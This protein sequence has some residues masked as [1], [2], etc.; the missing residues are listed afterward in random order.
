MPPT[1]TPRPERDVPE[2]RSLGPQ[3]DKK[4]H[5]RHADVLLRVLADRSVSAPKNIALAGHYGSGKS[6][7]IL[8][9]QE[10]LDARDIKWVNLSLSSLGTDN[11]KRGRVQEDGTLAPLTNLIQKE[12]VKQLLYRKAPKDMPGSRYFRIDSFRTGRAVQ[13]AIAAGAGVFA[14]AVLLGLVG[15]VEK[16]APRW[17]ANGP[18]WAPWAAVG[19]LG[20]FA[21]LLCFLALR[22]LQN[23]IKVDSISAGGA[24]VSLSAKENSYFDEYLDEIV[25]F[26]QQTK[27]Q[28]AI[29]EDLDRFKDP[30]IFETLRELNTVLNNSEQVKSRPVKFVYAVRDSIFE[31]L[32]VA[33]TGTTE[34]ASSEAEP[35][36][37]EPGTRAPVVA[38]GDLALRASAQES[39]PSANRTKFFDLVVPMVPF[40]THRSARDLL[41]EE[42]KTSPQR[43]SAAVINLIGG[44]R[45]LTDMRLI[46]NIRNEFEIYRASVLS[47]HGLQGLTA[48]R[49]FAM[50]V[51]KN[52][53]LEDFEAIRH[54]TSRI[55]LAHRAFRQFVEHQSRAQTSRSKAA[56][57]RA[58]SVIPWDQRARAVGKRLQQTL[59]LLQRANRN[60]GGA[61]P[62]I[63]TSFGTYTLADLESA[64]FWKK[65]H[66]SRESIEVG[67]P[68]YYPVTLAFD[69]FLMLGGDAGMAIKKLVEVDVAE[70]HRQS[71][72]ALDTR[73]FVTTATMAELIAR[74]DLTMP[75]EGSAEEL[76]LDEIVSGIVSPLAH[77]LLAQGLL[78]ENFTLYCSDYQGVAISVSAM[79]FILHCVQADQADPL[80]H[81]DAPA[82]I[83]AVENEVG[84]RFLSGESVFNVEVFDHYLTKNALRLENALGRLVVRASSGDT[85]FVDLYL[86]DEKVGTKHE[87]L[88]A[89][90]PLWPGV[91]AHLVEA[92]TQEQQ[93]EFVDTAL[94]AAVTD[95]AY[96]ASETLVQ[97]LS[98]RYAEM[99][100]FTEPLTSEQASTLV[101]LMDDLNMQVPD[102]SLLGEQQRRAVVAAGL[103]P[104]TRANLIAALNSAGGRDA[105]ASEANDVSLALDAAKATDNDIYTH[106][107][108]NLH[109]YLAALGTGEVTVEDADEFLGVLSDVLGA[110][111]GLLQ[112]VAERA[113]ESCV[114]RDLTTL[115]Q[116]GWLPVVAA[117]RFLASAS[118]VSHYVQHH[119]VTSELA[120]SLTGH[121][122]I[123]AADVD[124]EE[125]TTLAYALVEA[126][127]LSSTERVRLL[128]QL[129]FSSYLEP[130][131]LGPGGLS[132]LPELLAAGEV[133]DDANTYAVVA[134]R[135]YPFREKYFASAPELAS[136]VTELALSSDDLNQVMKSRDVP[137]NVKK[138][139]AAAPDFI[140]AHISQ[141]VA[142]TICDWALKGNDVSPALVL[143]LSQAGAPAE[144]V[145]PILEAHLNTM[146][147]GTLDAVLVALG[148][149]YEP[150]TRRG[151]HRP[152]LKSRAGTK[153][154]LDE[155]KRRDRVSSYADAM[156]G[157]IRVN[158][159]A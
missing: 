155:L 147:L 37:S 150:L 88:A 138:A 131:R 151:R 139:I 70:L 108:D 75:V 113:S 144:K 153:E 114:V 135:P 59:P 34:D 44:H 149:D 40:L 19:L 122:L 53:H 43:P 67:H 1:P 154:L 159:R 9:V 104:V 17:L 157:G 126:E 28:V 116:A 32:D 18:S 137:H 4:L 66:Q 107:V 140:S 120:Q 124:D 24:A 93:V 11:T 142:I 95:V 25:Y 103:Y 65:L 68:G 100:V 57:N 35:S 6:S 119:G 47:E 87:F 112:A 10:G 36:G 117:G 14:L 94:R 7:V 31:Q 132:M 71:R 127:D 41:A 76:N 27:T 29:F 136:Y 30:H 38:I 123:G 58:R 105:G 134:N 158:M 60:R 129:A 109:D 82:S 26:F 99:G 81:F 3:Y 5:G 12:I 91:F 48:N 98:E 56:T 97:L 128:K 13:W 8:G 83:D 62:Q 33:S 39:I 156:L 78:D 45:A 21:G 77:D 85:S 51:Y 54:G 55:D 22:G 148:D 20:V 125:K 89:L 152:R 86:E 130:S 16:V 69:E 80:F 111:D 64:D 15:R 63:I 141:R 121:D 143:V 42:F 61:E 146:E 46:R 110:P 79:N 102:L 50:V 118:N 73:E 106:V 74:T 2:L 115:A 90:A 49:L 133:P 92:S 52:T 84:E 96:E 101:A 23:P 72:E 145:L